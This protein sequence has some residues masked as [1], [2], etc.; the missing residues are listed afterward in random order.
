MISIDKEISN[1]FTRKDIMVESYI[2]K[3][4]AGSNANGQSDRKEFLI[5]NYKNGLANY[6][7]KKQ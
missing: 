2:K 7:E 6:L 1:K 5:M 3:Q 4:K